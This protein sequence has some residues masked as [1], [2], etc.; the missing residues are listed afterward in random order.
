MLTLYLKV[1]K[2]YS[3]YFLSLKDCVKFEAIISK[4]VITAKKAAQELFLLTRVCTVVCAER[5][6]NNADIK[7]VNME[8]IF[9]LKDSFFIVTSNKIKEGAFFALAWFGTCSRNK[10]LSKY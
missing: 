9:K 10:P 4:D 6:Q 3:I 8:I 5:D 2:F 7:L 1:I